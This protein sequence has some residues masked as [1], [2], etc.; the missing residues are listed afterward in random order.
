[1]LSR[2]DAAYA[3]ISI[4]GS[5]A[6]HVITVAVMVVFLAGLNV[7]VQAEE[8]EA[9]GTASELVQGN[10]TF[11]LELY[12]A[13]RQGEGNLL[14]SPYS[15][16]QAL[17]MTYAGAGGDTARQMAEVLHLTPPDEALFT[18]FR[19]L[20]EQLAERGG[21]ARGMDGEGFRLTVVN[22][23]WGQEDYL[24]RQEFLAL[25]EQSFG[26][27]VQW[28]N[29]AQ[30]PEAS[31]TVINDWVAQQTNGRITDLLSERA[32]TNNTRLV[33]TNAIYFNAAWQRPFSENRTSPRPFTLLDGAEIEVPTMVQ[34]N[35][36]AYV[37]ETGYQAVALPY[38]GEELSM[39]I[40][41]P[42]EGTFES[43]EASLDAVQLDHLIERLDGEGTQLELYL[44]RF[45]FTSGFQLSHTLAAMGMPDAFDA[46]RA[47]FSGMTQP[48]GDRL[49]IDAVIH[50]AFILT[51]ETGTEAAAATGVTF[52]VTSASQPP[53]AVHIDRPFVFLIR[54]NGTGVLLF[55]G[56]V[57]DPRE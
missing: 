34:T 8:D 13:L 51:N 52:G 40:V 36:F 15:I 48:Q 31:R 41:L 18:A 35:R 17:V 38:D 50:K 46:Q 5:V 1:M 11:A 28:A 54:D 37:Q 26:T 29:F 27:G 25:L 2:A 47:D 39:I 21:R 53:L 32:V 14:Y 55:V 33:L 4:Y 7:Q 3:S 12:Q 45:S 49:A 24:F 20:D 9:G 56:R 43:F 16:S 23:L 44:P 42:D 10:T 19:T 22:A 6:R 57:L 30:E